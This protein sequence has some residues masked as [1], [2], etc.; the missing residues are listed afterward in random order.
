M[1]LNNGC[2]SHAP[3]TS[4][5]RSFYRTVLRQTAVP[6]ARTVLASLWGGLPDSSRA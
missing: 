5:P 4:V 2:V 6:A 1:N 3:S